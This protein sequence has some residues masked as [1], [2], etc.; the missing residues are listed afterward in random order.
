MPVEYE[1]RRIHGLTLTVVD[2][3]PVKRESL[4]SING[5]PPSW[6]T[7]QQIANDWQP[8]EGTSNATPT[9]I[10]VEVSEPEPVDPAELERRLQRLNMTKLRALAAVKGITLPAGKVKKQQLIDPIV[11]GWHGPYP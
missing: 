4:C 3:S 1:H 5:G 9:E 8:A 10:T 11:E 2:Y 6:Y 7:D